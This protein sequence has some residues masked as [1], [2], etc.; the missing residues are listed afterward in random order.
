MKYICLS[1]NN[2]T[3]QGCVY[4]QEALKDSYSIE[5]IVR[6]KEIFF[7]KIKFILSQYI[8]KN[9]IQT[10]GIELLSLLFTNDET[11][12]SIIKKLN[13]SCK[14]RFD[15]RNKYFF[16]FQHVNSLILMD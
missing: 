4:L 2:I 8:S 16:C 14:T 12:M 11:K 3:A 6:K 10:A 1:N 7:V 9:P 13:L 5:E 15:H